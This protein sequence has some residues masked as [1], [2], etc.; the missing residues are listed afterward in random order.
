MKIQL[1]TTTGRTSEAEF[2]DDATIASVKNS[3]KDEYD[4]ASLRLCHQGKILEDTRLLSDLGEGAVL[5]I[6]GKKASIV[7]PTVTLP[8]AVPSTVADPTPTVTQSAVVASSAAKPTLDPSNHPSP[9]TPVDAVAPPPAVEA[10]P[11]VT[12]P[13][14]GPSSID[15]ELVSSIAAMG[16]DDLELV[17]L[18]LRAAYM[19]PDRA[20]DYLCSG[21]P[22]STLE[23]L[24]GE[25]AQQTARAVPAPTQPRAAVSPLEQAVAAIPNFDQIRQVIQ[26][27]PASLPTF[28]EQLQQ[29]HPSV[30]SLVQENPEEFLQ[31]IQTSG[32]TPSSTQPSEGAGVQ[33]T[34][35][36]QIAIQELAE[37]GGGAWDLQASAL[38]YVAV[39]RNKEV[40]A[41]VLFEHGGLP[42]QLVQAILDQQRHGSGAD[43][44]S[45]GDDDALDE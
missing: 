36:D 44:D 25:A 12:A 42:P 40:A 34:P 37:L 22:R 28:M 17:K 43:D 1:K 14:D 35:A 24:A 38:V 29:N 23:R 13:H 32:E 2:G 5:F 15:D 39:N 21:T 11:S 9:I 31:L 20:V 30:F 27:N 41:A 8:P 16:F 3:L 19:N 33:L 10:A 26:S 18:A 45:E 6:A 4:L 7:K